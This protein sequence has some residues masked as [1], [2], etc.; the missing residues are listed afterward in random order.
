MGDILPILSNFLGHMRTEKAQVNLRFHAVWLGPLI[1]YSVHRFYNKGSGP[2][3]RC[4]SWPRLLL[5]AYDIGPFFLRCATF[6]HIAKVFINARKEFRF[7]NNKL[8]R[9]SNVSSCYS[10]AWHVQNTGTHRTLGSAF[11]V[12]IRWNVTRLLFNILPNDECVVG[13]LI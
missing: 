11:F 7:G 4:A 9:T 2:T 1:F 13:R 5:S 10:D 3:G 8:V 12:H 6:T